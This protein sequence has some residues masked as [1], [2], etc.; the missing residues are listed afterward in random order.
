MVEVDK[1]N[2]IQTRSDTVLH[3]NIQYG[4]KREGNDG[5]I[6]S[7]DAIEIDPTTNEVVAI[8]ATKNAF[9]VF[10]EHLH[11]V[12]VSKTEQDR[13]IK[14]N[15]ELVASL[16]AHPPFKK[17]ADEFA[18]KR[19]WSDGMSDNLEL[20]YYNSE[21]EYKFNLY[22]WAQKHGYTDKEMY[23]AGWLER[24][25]SN[26]GE[27]KYSPA[28]SD[29][30]VIPFRNANGNIL[31]KRLR[32][33]NPAPGEAK[34]RDEAPRREL[35]WNYSLE[36][37]VRAKLY[38]PE[39]NIENLTEKE[40]KERI[41]T[42]GE[43]KG[44]T[45]FEATKDIVRCITGITLFDRKM[46]SYLVSEDP[47]ILYICFDLDPKLMGLERIN[48]MTDSQRAAYT[49]AIQLIRDGIADVRIMILPDLFNGAKIGIDDWL[50]EFPEEQR[51]EALEALKAAAL[52]PEQFVAQN[53][54]DTTLIDL[55]E[56]SSAFS[57]LSRRIYMAKERDGLNGLSDETC[58]KV[59][60]YAAQLEEAYR[61]Y[62][63]IEY[64][65]ASISAHHPNTYP[66]KPVDAVVGSTKKTFTDNK[67]IAIPLSKA[68][69]A[70]AMLTVR[71][72]IGPNTP[73]DGKDRGYTRF[74][75]SDRLE[76][77]RKSSGQVK[78]NHVDQNIFNGTLIAPFNWQ[79]L[80]KAWTL[81]TF[82]PVTDVAP[83][84]MQS[85]KGRPPNL[86]TAHEKANTSFEGL[87]Q[88]M[89]DL[90]WKGLE[91]AYLE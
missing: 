20:A 50:L 73:A 42:E 22:K 66:L 1:K 31:K 35:V 2:I 28:Y 79:D 26:K 23:R 57:G 25:V 62:L 29:V 60:N 61:L 65:R 27:L 11:T 18:K 7:I 49:F 87:P 90:F 5:R 77:I 30:G 40:K 9:E 33:M 67:G 21:K 75:L 56:R 59:H 81:K 58:E 36:E 37:Y 12:Q 4:Y 82:A 53:N 51:K 32:A 86:P 8:W 14:L 48:G 16:R 91:K 38:H 89:Q 10:T 88:K 39:G 70:I 64:G 52:T 71:P 6:G 15:T 34:Y 78:N 17:K 72:P 63:K 69:D 19:N 3:R 85:K 80:R 44:G 24:S 74:N 54:L 46:R 45:V 55:L 41:L 84:V 76:G 83:K 47:E 68:N 13:L 43:Y